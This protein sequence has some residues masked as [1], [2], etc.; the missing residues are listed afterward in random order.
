MIERWPTP[1]FGHVVD[2]GIRLGLVCVW[3]ATSA[4]GGGSSGDSAVPQNSEAGG[5]GEQATG[6]GGE[7][8]TDGGRSESGGMSTSMKQVGG[9]GGAVSG[10]GG[11]A[12]TNVTGGSG[13]KSVASGG[14]AGSLSSGQCRSNADCPSPEP[15]SSFEC[16][17][18]GETVKQPPL[19][20]APGWCGECGC[21]PQPLP[22]EG[23]GNP[24]DAPADCPQSGAERAA[25]VCG[26][27][28]LCAECVSNTDCGSEAPY[29]DFGP[30]GNECFECRADT[31]C[32]PERPRCLLTREIAPSLGF[33]EG[34]SC[35]A[36]RE[37]ADCAT[38]ICID[39]ACRPECSSDASCGGAMRAC[40]DER[41]VAAPCQE[42]DECGEF[43]ICTN[44][45][46]ARQT[47]TT[48]A[49]C[50]ATNACINHACYPEA[51]SCQ[52][53]YLGAP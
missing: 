19:C 53:I 21:P 26:D 33:G 42:A 18:P 5:G 29:C 30:R 17:P 8:A 39:Y 44:S 32:S 37:T 45:S 51:G 7:Q 52:R 6:G 27:N 46:C 36:C 10:S 43:G 9:S 50:G 35:V 2:L 25:S 11:G 24:C 23:A 13:G 31:D 15:T 22:I 12:G 48:D 41:C 14:V 16:V 4:C 20:G 47:C 40:L 3:L 34:G 49:D 28:G 38:G 1:C